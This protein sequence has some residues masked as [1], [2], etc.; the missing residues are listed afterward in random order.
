ML[1]EATEEL[2]DAVKIE[3]TCFMFCMVS[4]SKLTTASTLNPKRTCNGQKS[5][6]NDCTCASDDGCI[7]CYFYNYYYYGLDPKCTCNGQLYAFD[8]D[9]IHIFDGVINIFI[10][11]LDGVTNIYLSYNYFIAQTQNVPAMVPHVS[12]M[13][14]LYLQW[15]YPTHHNIM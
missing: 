12:L 2:M 1:A 3:V 9:F 4:F 11:T 5:V 13:T 15:L 6:F 7:S 8:G 14:A 10:Y